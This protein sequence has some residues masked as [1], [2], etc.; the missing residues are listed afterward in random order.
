MDQ[1]MIMIKM[2]NETCGTYGRS[3]SYLRRVD[4]QVMKVSVSVTEVFCLVEMLIIDNS[5]LQHVCH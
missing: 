3:I 1:C 4:M 5:C 2:T